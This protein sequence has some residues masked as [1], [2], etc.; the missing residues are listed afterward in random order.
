MRCVLSG[1]IDGTINIYNIFNFKKVRHYTHP[2]G[3]PIH[4]VAVSTSPLYAIV[5]FSKDDATFYSYSING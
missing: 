1:S 3:L 4:H 2:Y 5:M